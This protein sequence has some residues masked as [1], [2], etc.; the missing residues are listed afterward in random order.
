MGRASRLRAPLR[1]DGA[2]AAFE[3]V[4]PEPAARRRGAADAALRRLLALAGEA[5]CGLVVLDAAAPDW[6]QQWYS[7]RG[8]TTVGRSWDV[9]RPSRPAQAGTTAD[10]SR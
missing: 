9:V 5:G 4:L 10:S 6:P 7:R 1:I 8:S 2:T 3:W